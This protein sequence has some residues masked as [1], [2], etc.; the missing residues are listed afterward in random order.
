MRTQESPRQSANRAERPSSHR[1]RAERRTTAGTVARVAMV[2]MVTAAALVGG[3]T[4]LRDLERKLHINLPSIHLP[5]TGAQPATGSAKVIPETYR[6]ITLKT[7]ICT[8]TIDVDTGVKTNSNYTVFGVTTGGT[9]SNAS[10][11]VRFDVCAKYALPASAITQSRGSDIQQVSISL[12][13]SY[14]PQ[15]AGPDVYSDVL[16]LGLSST[17]TQKDINN[18]QAKYVAQV[19]KGKHP[20]ADTL[21]Q[22]HGI[23]DMGTDKEASATTLLAFRLAT[24]AGE[25]S[26]LPPTQ[27][28]QWVS[29]QEQFYTQ[30]VQALY[31]GIAPS[32]IRFTP[33]HEVS[34]VDQILSNMQADIPALHQDFGHMKFVHDGN[35]TGF[36][37]QADNAGGEVMI[38]V[39]LTDDELT[40]LNQALN[41]VQP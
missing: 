32:A 3:D 2:G 12:P 4:I 28:N 6:E 1:Y 36:K 22:T 33:P 15:S 24:L 41:P 26:P 30:E 18:A 21:I 29:D 5:K 27:Y 13:N 25:I 31:P 11:P 38:P 37:V 7:P 23:T 20:C 19:Q 10:V 35:E 14:V 9:N 39:Q 40:Q 17:A 34:P 8:D 16:C